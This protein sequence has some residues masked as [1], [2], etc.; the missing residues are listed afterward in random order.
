MSSTPEIFDRSLVRKRALRAGP[1]VPENGFLFTRTTE[2]MVDRLTAVNRSFPRAA[3]CSTDGPHLENLFQNLHDK[4]AERLIRLDLRTPGRNEGALG[5]IADEETL[6]FGAGSLDLILSI[7]SLHSVN[8]LPGALAQMRLALKPDGLFMAALLGGETLHELRTAFL[9][10]ES[11]LEG[12]ISPR[13]S[14]FADVRDMGGLLQRAGFALPV[15]DVDRIEVAYA[16]PIALLQDLR[17]MGW[18]TALKDRR[19]TFLR[20]KTFF[21]MMEIYT[22]RFTNKEG[23]VEATF[24]IIHL[25]GWAPH[26]SQQK[27]L[28]PGSAKVR[29]ADALKSKEIKV[30]D[31]T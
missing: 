22:N 15:T 8:D 17:A 26:E 24:D 18:T 31:E 11:E 7:L 30:E 28:R 9:E 14:P 27:P 23:K 10:A 21:R 4:D 1:L 29:L 20:R 13:V 6:P 16:S 5:L 19:K 12:G 25:T 3:V 2:D